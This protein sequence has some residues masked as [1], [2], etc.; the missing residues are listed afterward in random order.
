MASEI[1]PQISST[2]TERL[3][4]ED[5]GSLEADLYA[6]LLVG[7]RM[8]R[9]PLVRRIMPDLYAALDRE[10]ALADALR[11]SESTRG[12]KV[13]AVI[14]RAISRGELA[15]DIDRSLAA[16]ILFGSLYWRLVV[17]GHRI[18]RSQLRAL[19]RMTT[20]ALK[21]SGSAG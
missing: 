6:M 20:A 10:P 5:H 8:M 4:G 11:P 18:A 9:D 3:A 1:I 15:A 14:D 16:D 19:A 7:T 13:R 21:S 17:L 2:A 12:K